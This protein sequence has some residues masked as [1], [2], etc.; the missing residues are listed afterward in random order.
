MSQL[1]V[2]NIKNRTGGAV[3]F[4]TGVVVTGVATFNNQVSIAGT[5]SYEDVTNIDST[6][7]ITAKSG[8][9]LGS[10]GAG[11]TFTSAGYGQLEGGLVVSGVTTSTT[12]AVTGVATAAS[13]VIAGIVTTNA[14][15]IVAAGVIT[16]TS[17]SG[18]GSSLTGIQA[19]S[20][21]FVA[22][23]AIPI[24]RP[25]VINTD[26]TVGVVTA[27]GPATDSVG[28]KTT[29]TANASNT[30]ATFDS[31]NG[32]VVIAYEDGGNSSYGTAIVGTVTGT[33]VTFGSAAVF[34]S[35]TSYPNSIAFDS[36]NG[37]VVVVYRDVG[38]SS[39]GTAVVGTVS[40][41]SISFG[42]PVVFNAGYTNDMSIAFDSGNGK[43]VIAYR[44]QGG[45]S[46]YG[47]AIV[48]TVSGTSISFG[49]EVV[50]ESAATSQCAAVYDSSNGKVVIGYRDDGN[51]YYG[52]AVVGT[53]SGT[54]ISFG[55]ATV[56]EEGNVNPLRGVY[57]SANGKVVFAYQDGGNSSYGTAVVGTVSG[58]SISFG[59]PVVFESAQ[60]EHVAATFDATSGAEKVVI[61][62][63]DGGNSDYGT[64]IVG[65]VS[66]TS[67]SFGDPLVFNSA[68]T[69]ETGIT[70]DSANDKVVISYKDGTPGKASV[71]TTNAQV[72]TLTSENY[73]GIS[74][75]A[76]SDGETGKIDIISGINTSQSGLTT[77]RTLY[78][79]TTGGISTVAD[80][81]SVI[82]GT[83]IS[84]TKIIVK[85]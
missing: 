51:S 11:G 84:A 37:K 27:S 47:T 39:A 67:I 52:T 60:V 25:V 49:S 5:L 75:E 48:G 24:G 71:F 56:F 23:G 68:A 14:D 72:T 19:G 32:K 8:L 17:F 74:A 30:R 65:T 12:L 58:T 53:V 29:F 1:F 4:P 15:G 63:Y 21:N 83:S 35:A 41:T 9:Q 13:S 66:G 28:V 61:A 38:N 16:A 20:S 55:S 81:P 57:D 76:I 34:E 69:S 59:T 44:D 62:Y 18:D 2:D 22:S 42:T 78:V 77:A 64:A 46:S 43:M 26:G 85:G 45:N 31:T 6:G 50:F 3:G 80:T 70:Y 10:A 33:G 79:Q 54:S 82:A 73:I 40:G 7:I 36:T